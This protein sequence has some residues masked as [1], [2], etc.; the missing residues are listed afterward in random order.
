[1]NVANNYSFHICV[2]DAN[3]ITAMKKSF[4][5]GKK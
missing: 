5:D 2:K 3:Y 4:P 1:M